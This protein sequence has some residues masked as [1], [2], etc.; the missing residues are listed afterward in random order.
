[1]VCDGRG[2]PLGAVISPG[3]SNDGAWF[4]KAMGSV[5]IPQQRGRPKNRPICVIADKGYDAGHVREYLRSRHIQAVIPPKKLGEGRK[6]HKRGPKPKTNNKKYK[7]RNIIER[8]IG[9][10]KYCRRISSRYEKYQNSFLAMVHLAF[11]KLYL[12]NHF[13]DTT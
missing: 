4:E 13:S 2:T 7:Q 5:S 1:L 3:Q 12:K 8:L 10:L 11:I 9:W 6:C